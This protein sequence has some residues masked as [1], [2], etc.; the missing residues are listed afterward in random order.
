MK[1]QFEINNNSNIFKLKFLIFFYIILS[2]KKNI[3]IIYFISDN[4]GDKLNVILL[5]QL[6]GKNIYFNTPLNKSEL[7]SK[8]EENLKILNEIASTDLI[9]IGSTLEIITNW[10][11]IFDNESNKFKS[12]ISKWS[13]KIYDYVH[14]LIIFGAGFIS[15]IN[16]TESYIRNLKVIAVRGNLTL[17]RLKANGIKVSKDVILADPGILFPLIFNSNFLNKSQNN[18]QLCIIPHYIDQNNTLI[19]KNINVPNSFILN[20]TENP[21]KFVHNLLKC[22]RV[23][24]S[25]LHG[26]I[27][28]DSFGIPNARIIVSDKIAGGDYKFNDYYSSF[29]IDYHLKFDL[30]KMIFELNHVHL[31][32]NNYKI[33]LDMIKKKQCQLLIHFP[34][35]SKKILYLRKI[36][37]KNKI[38]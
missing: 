5:K 13:F 16:K 3:K 28:S 21:I 1:D 35:I 4:L 9:F 20:I 37:C 7:K 19:Q 8:D 15:P 32:D 12:I 29:G 10:I 34:F 2:F 27:I 14:P 30:R 6:I 18:Y 36:F 26:L 33:S 31:I 22:K 24:S 23:I 17:Q 11:Y 25:S 38:F